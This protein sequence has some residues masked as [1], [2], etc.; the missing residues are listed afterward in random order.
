MSRLMKFALLLWLCLPML[1]FAGDD[2]SIDWYTVDGGGPLEVSNGSWTLSAT[3]GQWDA[4]SA[5]A[6]SGGSWQLTG[7]FWSLFAEFVDRIFD[8]RFQV[9]NGIGREEANE[10]PQ[11]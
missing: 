7:G 3:I 2:W 6:L 5:N 11:E 8:D 9:Q 4:T 1:A 10:R